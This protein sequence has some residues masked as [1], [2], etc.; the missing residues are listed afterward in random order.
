[1]FWA[2][3]SSFPASIIDTFSGISYGYL[4]LL[5]SLCPLLFIYYLLSFRQ[6]SG[7][8]HPLTDEKPRLCKV[9]EAGQVHTG[10][11]NQSPGPKLWDPCSLIYWLVRSVHLVA[12]TSMTFHRQEPGAQEYIVPSGL[13]LILQHQ[14]E[15]GGGMEREIGVNRYKLLSV[16]GI[17]NK[18][19]M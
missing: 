17:N 4:S 10:D 6:S 5:T 13:Q 9:G 15:V 3:Q 8:L 1:M 12:S 18:V 7:S 19:R 2:Q 14:W 16:E 11:R